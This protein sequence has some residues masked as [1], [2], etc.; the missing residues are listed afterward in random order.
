MEE[1]KSKTINSLSN[2]L[3]NKRVCYHQKGT[4]TNLTLLREE[5]ISKKFG[6]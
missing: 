4:V 1:N 5:R 2:A 3:T 6:F